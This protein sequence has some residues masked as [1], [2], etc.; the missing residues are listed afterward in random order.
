MTSRNLGEQHKQQRGE[1]FVF[2]NIKKKNILKADP[3]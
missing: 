2:S 3:Q 1:S